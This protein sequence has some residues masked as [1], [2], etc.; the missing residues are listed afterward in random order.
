M[1]QALALHNQERRKSNSQ[2][3]ILCQSKEDFQTFLMKWTSDVQPRC[4]ANVEKCHFGNY[5]TLSQLN[6]LYGDNA[7]TSWLMPQLYNLSEYCGVRDK[8][9]GRP[10]EECARIITIDFSWL[11]VSEMMLFLHRFKSGRY[12]RFYG[13]VDPLIIT[14]SLRTFVDERNEAYMKHEQQERE[15]REAE[16]RK[17]VITPEEYCR[18][19]GINLS[20]FLQR[21]KL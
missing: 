2:S 12:G 17:N 3:D 15:K 20:S 14:T 6:A 21:L 8:L 16:H 18:R 19:H 13:V 9:Q 7:A 5:P 1:Q 4:A 11:K 10:L